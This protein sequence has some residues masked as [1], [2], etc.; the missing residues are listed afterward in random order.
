[1]MIV[2]EY[3][4]LKVIKISFVWKIFICHF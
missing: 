2:E 3:L 1:M 4:N